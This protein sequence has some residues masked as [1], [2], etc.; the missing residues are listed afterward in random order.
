MSKR[1]KKANWYGMRGNTSAKPWSEE[2]PQD[3]IVLRGTQSR[4]ARKAAK[5]TLPKLPP[6]DEKDV[7]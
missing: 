2:I 6:W 4:H 3:K 7:T 5:P 1:V